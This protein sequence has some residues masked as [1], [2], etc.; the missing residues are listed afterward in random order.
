MQEICIIG[1][2]GKPFTDRNY[3]KFMGSV[4]G[5]KGRMSIV[6]DSETAPIGSIIE[7]T[8]QW[9]T[10]K[11]KADD[12]AAIFALGQNIGLGSVK[13]L[14]CGRFEVDKLEIQQDD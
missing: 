3:H 1:P 9:P 10:K 12:M 8:V 14:E 2:D 11:I 7:F 5:P 4:S 6:H 13:S